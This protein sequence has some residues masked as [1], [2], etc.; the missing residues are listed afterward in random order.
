LVLGTGSAHL[1]LPEGATADVDGIAPTMGSVKSVVP[2]Q[3]QAGAAHFVVRGR[4]RMGSVMVR[5][6]RRFAG[7]RF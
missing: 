1:M 3:R 2:S 4:T 5:R 7:I 6:R